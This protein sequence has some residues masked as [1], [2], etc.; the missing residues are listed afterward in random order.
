VQL[1]GAVEGPYGGHHRLDSYGTVVL[2]A[3]G[4]GITHQ[5]PFVRQLLDA[6]TS[7]MTATRKVLLVWCI[8]NVEAIEWIQPWLDELAA[9]ENFH[10]VVRIRIHVS[11][12]ASLEE[13]RRF[14]AYIDYQVQRC[15][16]QE[17]IDEEILTQVGAMSVSV[18]GSGAF[19][20]SVREAV[21]RRVCMRSIDYF[22]EAFSY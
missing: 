4:V 5:L 3:A 7:N 8:A 20:D 21:R 14:P 12:L 13:G 22:E 2:F 19:T 9:M 15:D 10:D 18:C 1:W 6:H 16:P 11:K 17:A